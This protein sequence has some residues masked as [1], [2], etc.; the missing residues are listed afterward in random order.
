MESR[1]IVTT[2][3][4]HGRVPVAIL[5][6]HDRVN[7]GNADQLKQAARQVV[8]GGVHNILLDLSD[9]PS[10]TSAGLSAILAIYKILG[11][12]TSGEGGDPPSP[13]PPGQPGRSR[14]LKLLKP[15]PHVRQV[16]AVAGLDQYLD[17]YD[18]AEEALAA[19]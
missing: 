19:F 17:I 15:L 4:G 6:V 7:L 11:Q 16:L 3:Q 9:V 2:S 1:T 12:D 5:H 10:I 18:S 14:H 13:E 8:A